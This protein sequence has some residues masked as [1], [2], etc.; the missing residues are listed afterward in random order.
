MV[1]TGVVVLQCTHALIRRLRSDRVA[2][3]KAT[4]DDD[5]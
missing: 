2:I 1:D 4:R 5:D 3:G